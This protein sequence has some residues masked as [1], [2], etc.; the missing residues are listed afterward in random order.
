MVRF[1]FDNTKR[2][3]II[4]SV[5]GTYSPEDIARVCESLNRSPNAHWVVDEIIEEARQM[6]LIPPERRKAQTMQAILT[7]VIP[8]TDTKPTRIKA[9]CSR[10]ALMFSTTHLTVQVGSDEAH[11]EAAQALCQ[12][13]CDEDQKEY[14]THRNPWGGSFVTGTLPNGDKCHVFTNGNHQ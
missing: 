2:F 11:R 5:K 14:G 12:R 4:G 6:G 10:G 3:A 13:F 8:A 9:E 1:S 7:K